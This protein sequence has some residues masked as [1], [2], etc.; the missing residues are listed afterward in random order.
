MQNLYLISVSTAEPIS[1]D[2]RLALKDALGER[3]RLTFGI[4]A[5]VAIDHLD[6]DDLHVTSVL[7]A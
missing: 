4:A 7:P 2:D 5:P 1:T 6:A 3:V